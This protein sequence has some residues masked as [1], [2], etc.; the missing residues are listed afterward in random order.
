MYVMSYIGIF[1]KPGGQEMVAVMVI[2]FVPVPNF[3]QAK[4]TAYAGGYISH[5][6]EGGKM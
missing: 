5:Y 4:A 3:Y 6:L 2:Y 1:Q